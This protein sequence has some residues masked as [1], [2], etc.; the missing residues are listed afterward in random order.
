MMSDFEMLSIMLGIITLLV[1]VAIA[2]YKAGKS[3]KK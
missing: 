3:N 2:A 1:T